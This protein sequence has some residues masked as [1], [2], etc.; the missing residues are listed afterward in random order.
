LELRKLLDDIANLKAKKDLGEED[1][2][3][4]TGMLGYEAESSGDGL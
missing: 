4:C 1:P 3:D 2:T